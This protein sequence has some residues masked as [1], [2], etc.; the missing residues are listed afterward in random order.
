MLSVGFELVSG[1]RNEPYTSV[2]LGDEG[3][4][5]G[6]GSLTTKFVLLTSGEVALETPLTS[7]LKKFRDILAARP[8][9]YL[10]RITSGHPQIP[11]QSGPGAEACPRAM[12]SCD[13]RHTLP[14]AAHP[15][16]QLCGSQFDRT[17]GSESLHGGCPVGAEADD[18]SDGSVTY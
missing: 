12:L 17:R 3:L 16:S 6:Q 7:P 10:R 9:K 8:I 4:L 2:R 18:P 15:R 13:R 5:L 14:R 1:W 11:R